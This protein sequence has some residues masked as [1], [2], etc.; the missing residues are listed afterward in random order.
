MSNLLGLCSKLSTRTYNSFQIYAISNTEFFFLCSLTKK[1]TFKNLERG[2][3]S[4]LESV[5]KGAQFQELSGKLVGTE[6]LGAEDLSV[7]CPDPA[8]LMSRAKAKDNS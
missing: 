3:I 2:I 8:V 7:P 6:Q 5:V 4:C 1:G